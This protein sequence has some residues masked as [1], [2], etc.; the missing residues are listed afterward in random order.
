MPY[1]HNP[2]RRGDDGRIRHIDVPTLMQAPD[3]FAQ[4]RI[5]LEELGETLPDRNHKGE[6]PWLLA[7]ESTKDSLTWKVRRGETLMTNFVT[8]FKDLA[9]DER[10]TFRNRYPEPPAWTGF[11]DSLA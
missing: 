4:L 3:G 1:Q 5:A 10:Q 2:I 11:Y 6:P 7:P 8:W 9:P